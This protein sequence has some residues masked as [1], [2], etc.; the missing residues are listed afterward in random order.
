MQLKKTVEQ[1]LWASAVA[2]L[3]TVSICGWMTWC[4]YA[5]IGACDCSVQM[6]A[7]DAM[8][9]QCEE[10]ISHQKS[11]TEF[12]QRE[13]AQLRMLPCDLCNWCCERMEN[14][15]RLMSMNC[16]GASVCDVVLESPTRESVMR[17]AR[18]LVYDAPWG[19]A[20]L[21][22]CV[23]AQT[24]DGIVWRSTIRVRMQ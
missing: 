24:Q 1:W 11:L 8:S 16:D 21:R 3:L 7:C 22:S 18:T 6:P 17:V 9:A 23:M 2:L 12:T 19:I 14:D 13:D 4:L 15:V 20:E 10:L 5:R